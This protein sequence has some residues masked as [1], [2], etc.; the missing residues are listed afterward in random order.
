MTVRSGGYEE[1]R[2]GGKGGKEKKDKVSIKA[3]VYV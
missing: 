3:Q 2:R 1:K